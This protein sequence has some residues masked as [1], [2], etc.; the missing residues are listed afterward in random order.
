MRQILFTIA[1]ALLVALMV[2]GTL[3]PQ[4]QPIAHYQAFVPTLAPIIA[5]LRLND[6]YSSPLFLCLLG[7]LALL[8]SERAVHAIWQYRCSSEAFS[9]P[10]ASS[11]SQ[12][13]CALIASALLISHCA[14]SFAGILRLK[15]GQSTAIPEQPEVSIALKALEIGTDSLHRPQQYTSRLLITD[16]QGKKTELATSVSHP[17]RHSGIYFYQSGAGV[18]SYELVYRDSKVPSRTEVP[19]QPRTQAAVLAFPG[20]PQHRFLVHRFYPHARWE[21]GRIA[22]HS[23]IPGQGAAFIIELS[24][25]PSGHEKQPEHQ[26]IGYRPLGWITA[27]TS[28]TTS[29]GAAITLGRL[30]TYSAIRYKRDMGY[31]CLILG[32]ILLI[33]GWCWQYCGAYKAYFSKWKQ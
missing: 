23:S 27:R 22:E 18:S 5:S 1:I 32:C 8:F 20:D 31:P 25:K 28:A 13:G 26:I 2:L 19:L 11:L 12:M 6:V 24:I 9:N 21:N 30:N 10:Y 16:H 15:E 3:L 4:G 33:S 29:S 17:A 7:L 14:W